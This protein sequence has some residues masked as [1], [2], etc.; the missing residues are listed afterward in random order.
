HHAG[1]FAIAM[2]RGGPVVF[3][4]MPDFVKAVARSR[5]VQAVLNVLQNPIVAPFLFVGLLYFWLIPAIHTRV[6]L[7]ANLYQLMNWTMAVNGVMFWSLIL[8]NRPRP[9]ACLSFLVRLLL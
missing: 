3:A 4:G 7:D 2:G 8:D 5:P 6:M 9:P 1:A